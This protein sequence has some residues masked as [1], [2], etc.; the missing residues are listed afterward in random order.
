MTTGDNT[1]N[2]HTLHLEGK[3]AAVV[4]KPFDAFELLDIIRSVLKD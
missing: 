4:Y 2:I 1:I 3:A